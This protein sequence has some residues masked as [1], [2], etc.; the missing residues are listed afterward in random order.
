M[1]LNQEE[2]IRSSASFAAFFSMNLSV[3]VPALVAIN[4]EEFEGAITKSS[5][6]LN[7]S[8]VAVLL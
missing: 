5:S 6:I 8:A 2:C 4:A 1:G 7:L 3:D